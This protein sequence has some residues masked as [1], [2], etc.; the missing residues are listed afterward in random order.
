MTSAVVVAVL[1]AATVAVIVAIRRREPEPGSSA[2]FARRDAALA[3][4][5]R[6]V[7]DDLAALGHDLDWE[8]EGTRGGWPAGTCQACG[9]VVTV[10]GTEAG[11]AT[12]DYGGFDGG[13]GVLL[14]C[15]GPV[16]V[17]GGAR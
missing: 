3:S 13:P 12:A 14:A 5:A 9:A 4:L 6:V 17:Q 15:P 7:H 11:G 8:V 1:A 2:W 16:T 10:Y